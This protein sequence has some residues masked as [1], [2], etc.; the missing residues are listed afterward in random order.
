MIRIAEE[1]NPSF[2]YFLSLLPSSSSSAS[3][4]GTHTREKARKQSEEGVSRCVFFSLSLCGRFS[5]LVAVISR[6][7]RGL[8]FLLKRAEKK[9]KKDTTASTS[10]LLLRNIYVTKHHK[11][12]SQNNSAANSYANK[13]ERKRD[14]FLRRRRRR[15]LYFVR[16]V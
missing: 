6:G 3:P 11:R 8:N 12:F 4:G 16:V 5:T 14:L 2:L 9:R 13:R 7:S 15:R 1:K 10:T